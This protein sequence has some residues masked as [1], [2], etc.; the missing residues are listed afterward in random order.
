M[1]KLLLIASLS[2]ATAQILPPSQAVAHE[3]AGH[4]EIIVPKMS[5]GHCSGVITRTLKKMAG[6]NKVEVTLEAR[7]VTVDFDPGVTSEAAIKDAIVAAG[8]KVN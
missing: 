1:K 5:C 7:K 6:V 3:T 8:F 4:A 2:L